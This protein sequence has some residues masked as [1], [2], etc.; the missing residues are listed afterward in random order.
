MWLA[1]LKSSN[2]N[3]RDLKDFDRTVLARARSVVAMVEVFEGLDDPEVVGVRHDVDDGRNALETAVRLA[4]WEARHGYRS[5]YFMLHTARYWQGRGFPHALDQIAGLGHEIGIH[6]NAI[7]EAL[8]VG[9]DPA[10]IL[11]GALEQLRVWGHE[12]IGVAPHGDS[13]CRDKS[14]RLVFVNDEMFSECARP[15]WARPTASFGAGTECYGSRPAARRVRA[16]VR[17]LP[18]PARPLPFGQRRPLERSAGVGRDRG[19]A[20]ARS[21]APGLVGEGVQ[22][23]EVTPMNLNG[24]R[25]SRAV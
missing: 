25:S 9:G 19:R 20:V 10:E 24:W 18:A 4:L 2:F 6:A 16:R 12:V 7:A 14:G 15:S 8:R 22:V 23:Q 13:V 11:D 17:D 21:A 3:H 1:R 5:T